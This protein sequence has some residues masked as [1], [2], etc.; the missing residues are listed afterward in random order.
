MT[1]QVFSSFFDIFAKTFT[2]NW[3]PFTSLM[4]STSRY[5]LNIINAKQ[6]TLQFL[7]NRIHEYEL[8]LNTI[9]AK[10]Q[11]LQSLIVYWTDYF[12]VSSTISKHN[13]CKAADAVFSQKQNTW[14]CIE[15][16]ILKTARQ[17]VNTI[18]A[19]QPTLQSLKNRIHEYAL[20]WLF[21]RQLDYK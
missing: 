4:Y 17:Q 5:A 2:L 13:K 20:T 14:V 12:K 10:Q 1:C 7:K 19:K 8:Q 3:I 6:P 11:T 16:I 18:N 9:N 15:L 21:E